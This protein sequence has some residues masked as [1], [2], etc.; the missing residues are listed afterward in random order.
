MWRSQKTQNVTFSCGIFQTTPVEK[1]KCIAFHH[2]L[3]LSILLKMP[4]DGFMVMNMLYVLCDVGKCM[5]RLCKFEQDCTMFKLQM[6]CGYSSEEKMV[7]GPFLQ[8]AGVWAKPFP[9]IHLFPPTP[10]LF[11]SCPFLRL[12]FS[13]SGM[14]WQSLNV[15]ST[16]ASFKMDFS[17]LFVSQK[18]G[19]L[20]HRDPIL[21][22]FSPLLQ[23]SMQWL[24][25]K[26][27]ESRVGLR[28]WTFSHIGPAWQ[29]LG[30][31]QVQSGGRSGMAHVQ[32]Y[33]TSMESH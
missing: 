21:D 5:Q 28:L 17:L 4:S 11:P 19:G 31:I 27:W 10:P 9:H 29:H 26:S 3:N 15:T 14:W 16:K 13:L 25:D 12:F 33:H 8:N 6:A 20:C 18:A 2:F 22:I 30:L 7:H 1:E 32:R 24:N 23:F